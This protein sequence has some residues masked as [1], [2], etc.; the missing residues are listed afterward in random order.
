M[1]K[2]HVPWHANAD[3]VLRRWITT[4]RICTENAKNKLSNNIS[5]K[6]IKNTRK[7]KKL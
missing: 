7:S 6:L 4:G 5:A 2:S 1:Q 3:M